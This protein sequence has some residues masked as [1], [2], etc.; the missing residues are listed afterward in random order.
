MTLT[1]VLG[2]RHFRR[3]FPIPEYAYPFMND[4]LGGAGI[5]TAWAVNKE[6]T[7]LL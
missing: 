5:V 7:P 6:K 3:S 4:L 2:Y 1:E